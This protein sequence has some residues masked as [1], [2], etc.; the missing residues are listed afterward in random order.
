MTWYAHSGPRSHSSAKFRSY[1]KMGTEKH[2]TGGRYR[3]WQYSFVAHQTGS[4]VRRTRYAVTISDPHGNHVEYLRDF[5]SIDQATSAAQQWIDRKLNWKLADALPAEV[6]TIP[7]LPASPVI[8]E[9]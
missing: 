5:S 1:T 3:D 8:Q 2:S 6:G 9:K 4:G 7:A